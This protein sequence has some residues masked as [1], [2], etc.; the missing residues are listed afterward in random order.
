MF[1]LQVV[2]KLL[3]IPTDYWARFITIESDS[4]NEKVSVHSFFGKSVTQ[5]ANSKTQK[6]ESNFFVFR[7]A[8]NA[9]NKCFDSTSQIFRNPT[10]HA[11][12]LGYRLKL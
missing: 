7:N 12:T 1:Q 4:E 9:A 5:T 6:F 11:K 8:R 2:E 3:N 10:T